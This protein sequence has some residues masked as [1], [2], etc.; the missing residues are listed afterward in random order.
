MKFAQNFCG[1][2]LCEIL[3]RNFCD[4]FP[5]EI[6]VINLCEIS[7]PNLANGKISQ[8]QI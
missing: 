5:R 3:A 2:F 7:A 6:F 1:K 8:A 4:K